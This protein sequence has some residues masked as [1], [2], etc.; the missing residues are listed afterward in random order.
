MNRIYYI[1]NDKPVKLGIVRLIDSVLVTICLGQKET[2]VETSDEYPEGKE[3][4]YVQY[5]GK[6]DT[7]SASDILSEICMMGDFGLVDEEFIELLKNECKLSDEDMLSIVK[8][9]Q[10]ENIEFYDTSEAVN[11]FF[12]NDMPMWIPR[13]TRISL[14]NSTSI[15]KAVGKTTTTLWYGTASFEIPCDIM[16]QMLSALEIY[17]LAAYNVTAQHKAEVVALDNVSD[18]LA[19]DVT[20][21]YPEKLSFTL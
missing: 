1:G 2:D 5:S 6:Y 11:S 16:I 15:E 20:K 4:E 21:S 18:I 12:M 19:Y 3:Y 17:A 13:D 7:L 8:E 14:M 9:A 10:I